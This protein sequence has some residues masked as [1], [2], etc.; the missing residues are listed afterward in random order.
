MRVGHFRGW[1]VYACGKWFVRVLLETEAYVFNFDSALVVPGVVLDLVGDAGLSPDA[2][3]AVEK[4]R[5]RFMSNIMNACM[6]LLVIKVAVVGLG[7]R[8]RRHEV[9]VFV[10][11][12]LNVGALTSQFALVEGVGEDAAVCKHNVFA[13]LRDFCIN[14]HLLPDLDHVEKLSR[15]GNR[16]GAHV[17][18][19][20]H[21]NSCDHVYH[22][23]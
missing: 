7:M 18:H 12:G 13:Y 20:Q 23:S 3:V 16:D 10:E 21:A 4:H 22:G 14:L 15:E 5:Y 17:A 11:D 6:S 19:P 1:V 9:P 2:V 8:D